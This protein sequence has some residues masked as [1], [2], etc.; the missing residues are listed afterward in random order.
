MTLA[1]IA[2]ESRPGETRVAATPETVGRMVKHGLTVQVAAG[3]GL[4][5]GIADAAYAAAGATLVG[6]DAAAWSNADLLLKVAAPTAAEARSLK[7]GVVVVSYLDGVRNLDSARA[8]AA[9]GATSFAME[10]VP[11]TTKAQKMDALS[12]QA[13]IAGYKAVLIAAAALPK[14]FPMLMTAAGT[15]RPARVVIFGVGVAGLQA[16]ATAKRLGAI[17]EATDIRPE[18]KEQVESLGG[19]FIEVKPDEAA[20]QPSV[21]AK[22][23]SEDYKRRQ[24][25]AVAASVA[26]ADVVI[27]TAQVPGKKAPILVPEDMVKAMK[28]GSV[29]VDLAA[30]QGGNCPL[31][32][33][34]RTVVKHGVSIIGP[35]NLPAGTA[36]H[37][38]ELYARNVWAAVEHLVPAK[39]N[40]ARAIKVDLAEEICAGAV[41]IHAGEIR[42][43]P[44]A[45]ALQTPA[46]A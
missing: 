11:R 31:S 19:K 24:R 13:N 8:L 4:N 7:K 5:A 30:E 33:P 14:Y 36:V 45:Q 9:A 17:V 32:E 38:S 21:Y 29:I 46:T 3:A 18:T 40:D 43:A 6:A 42:H 41:A 1:F 22:E 37:A 10:L 35:V 23:A 2:L 44:T 39:N 27:T 25:E 26:A 12:S 34:G 28:P 16:I 20:A 15:V